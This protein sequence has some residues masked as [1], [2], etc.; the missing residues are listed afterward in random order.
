LIIDLAPA[1]CDPELPENGMQTGGTT[2]VRPLYH[3][4]PFITCSSYL[5]R[6]VVIKTADEQSLALI[7]RHRID[8]ASSPP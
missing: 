7:E 6:T 5:R 2:L 4:G 1:Q 3:A 8:C